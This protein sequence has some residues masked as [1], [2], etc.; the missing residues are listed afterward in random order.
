MGKL[1]LEL[2]TTAEVSASGGFAVTLP[3]GVPLMQF[4][5]DKQGKLATW[6]S[7]ARD[8]SGRQAHLAGFAGDHFGYA[9]EGV[10][11][12]FCVGCHAGHTVLPGRS[13]ADL[14][15]AP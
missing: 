8:S 13:I 12:S 10:P 5:R 9:S 7:A 6:Q 4:P 2:V 14:M 1:A 15:A 3:A 11:R